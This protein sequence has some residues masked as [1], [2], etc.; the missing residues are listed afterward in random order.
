MGTAHFLPRLAPGP[1]SWGPFSQVADMTEISLPYDRIKQLVA[2][3]LGVTL[4]Q[5][6]LICRNDPDRI[7]EALLIMSELHSL[8]SP[9][10]GGQPLNNLHEWLTN[11]QPIGYPLARMTGNELYGLILVREYLEYLNG[12]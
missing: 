9:K 8:F 11:E 2:D 4:D 7:R 10:L 6:E 1:Q 5:A 3:F 12:R